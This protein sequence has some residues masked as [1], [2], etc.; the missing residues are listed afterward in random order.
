M[1]F[2]SKHSLSDHEF[3]IRFGKNLHFPILHL[4]RSFE[5]YAQLSGSARVTVGERVYLLRAGEAVLV[6]PFQ[7][8]SYLPEESGEH[9]L[10]FFAPELVSDYARKTKS[11]LPLDSRFC[12]TPDRGVKSDNIFLQRAIA[13]GICGA[14]DLGRTYA[15]V[16][17]GLSHDVLTRLLLYAEKNFRSRCLLRDAA[18]Q[19][20][21]DYAY[22]SKF[23][24]RRIGLSFH[25]YVILLRISEGAHLLRSSSIPIDHVK[26][27]CGFSCLRTFDREFLSVM[28]ISPSEYRKQHEK[29]SEKI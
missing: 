20:G 17:E 25:R 23:F 3:H 6:F 9:A 14:F 15:P 21:Y 24:K 26:D 7:P 12:Y 11:L 16:P 8:H 27:A 19:I 2:E 5:F 28:G 10:C 13:Y 18:S 22:L 4:H 1:L 29:K